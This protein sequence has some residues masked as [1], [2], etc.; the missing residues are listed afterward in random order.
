MIQW[1]VKKI[2]ERGSVDAQK[3]LTDQDVVVVSR[4]LLLL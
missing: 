2:E 1:L 3:S 4:T